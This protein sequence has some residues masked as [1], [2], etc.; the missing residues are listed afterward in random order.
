MIAYFRNDSLDLGFQISFQALFSSNGDEVTG[1][2]DVAFVNFSTN[3]P[4]LFNVF[5]LSSLIVHKSGLT[6]STYNNYYSSITLGPKT[7]NNVFA[8]KSIP[9]FPPTY[10]AY[11][12]Y[13]IGIVGIEITSSGM[14]W[15]FDRVE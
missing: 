1:E 7:F 9:N 2:S 6:V 3:Y 8:T 13:E 14:L 15:T 5:G 12:N 4:N 11:M 10:I